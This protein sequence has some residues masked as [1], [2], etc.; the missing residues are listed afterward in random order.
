MSTEVGV[1]WVRFP[2][3]SW[4]IALPDQPGTFQTALA[5]WWWTHCGRWAPD[6]EPQ[7][8][9]PPDER[10]CETCFRLRERRAA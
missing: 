8:F 6:Q 9:P 10:T 3:R 4:H 7:A 5:G 2:G 1:K